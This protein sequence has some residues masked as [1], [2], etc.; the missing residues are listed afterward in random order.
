MNPSTM[1]AKG[2]ASKSLAKRAAARANGAQG[3]RPRTVWE[4]INKAHQTNWNIGSYIQR[5]D[6]CFDRDGYALFTDG[7]SAIYAHRDEVSRADPQ[8]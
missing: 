5:V 7:T 3:G 6:S 8:K 2:G 4:V 1:G